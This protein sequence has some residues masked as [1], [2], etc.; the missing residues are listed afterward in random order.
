M[1]P[2]VITYIIL[3]LEK[4]IPMAINVYHDVA[5]AIESSKELDAESKVKLFSRLA[6]ATLPERTFVQKPEPSGAEG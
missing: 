5:A 6:K 2:A 4:G 1:S 3:A